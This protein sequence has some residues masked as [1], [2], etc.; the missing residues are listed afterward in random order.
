MGVGINED[1]NFYGKIEKDAT[2]YIYL[3]WSHDRFS[4]KKALYLKHKGKTLEDCKNLEKDGKNILELKDIKDGKK[5]KVGNARR[6]KD[7]VKYHKTTF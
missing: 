2:L 1:G 4:V 6:E 5:V 7:I 3:S